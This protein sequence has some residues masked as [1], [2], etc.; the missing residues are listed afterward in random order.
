MVTKKASVANHQ[1]D[2]TYVSDYKAGTAFHRV[3]VCV[4]VHVRTPVREISI[5][6]ADSYVCKYS[7]YLVI[8][9]LRLF[10]NEKET[11]LT[12]C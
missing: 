5:F 9:T 3:C 2:S 8:Q 10:E 4:C 6:S 7:I 1:P 11:L 12:F